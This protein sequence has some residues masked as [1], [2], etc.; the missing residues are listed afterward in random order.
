MYSSGKD[1]KMFEKNEKSDFLWNMIGS[2]VYAMSTVFMSYLTI[3]IVGEEKGGIFAIALTISQ[4]LV[5]F[6]YFEMR[7]YQVTDSKDRY[8]FGQYFTTKIYTCAIM[9]L[10]SIGY[11][12]LKGYDR[13]KAGIVLLVC[14]LKLIDAFADVYESQ[15]HKDGYLYLAGKS[16]CH[17]TL[18]MMAIYF[19]M[20]IMTHNLVITMII[21]D[22]VAV[23]CVYIFDIKVYNKF[24]DK[25]NL[26]NIKSV[27][28]I[29]KNCFPLFLGV[30]LWAYILSAPRLAVDKYMSSEYQSYYQ[31]IFLPVSVINLFAGFLFR[32]MLIT[33]TDLNEKKEFRKFFAI[34]F[35]M[36]SCLLGITVVCLIGAYLLGIPV[37]SIATGCELS[38][39][40]SLLVFTI[41]AG[42]I[43]SVAFALYYILTI[44][45]TKKLIMTGY[46][47]SAISVYILS[48][49]L[50]QQ[51]ELFGASM[52][53][54]VAVCVLGLF[55]AGSIIVYVLKVKKTI[56]QN[57]K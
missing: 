40:R 51:S 4:M 3:R 47:L 2:L 12:L 48:D 24:E 46:I 22:V 52:S 26:C 16:M 41:A 14:I 6:G 32:P 33:L 1:I 57:I 38:A 15:F 43:N 55:F 19:I 36:L 49:R 13:E 27:L 7:N 18:I 34:I 25:F 20:L 37:L 54:F 30:F 29:M 5:Y 9:L 56:K 21:S 31:A 17:R 39:Y 28:E 50:V 10:V 53:F 45:R 11:I 8:T 44:F 35:K 42:G 23:I